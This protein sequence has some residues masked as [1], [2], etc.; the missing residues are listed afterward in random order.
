MCQFWPPEYPKWNYSGNN[1]LWDSGAARRH[2]Q[3]P[4]PILGWHG[5]YILEGLSPGE[6]SVFCKVLQGCVQREGMV[7]LW[8]VCSL[9]ICH[10]KIIVKST[11]LTNPSLM[12]I[13]PVPIFL[14]FT[15][16]SLARM[17]GAIHLIQLIQLVIIRRL[18]C[19]RLTLIY[20]FSQF[21]KFSVNSRQRNTRNW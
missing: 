14:V 2:Q 12:L 7:T 9:C 10:W 13:T 5:T 19:Y 18:P 17:S 1:E 15:G 8:S 11:C 20:L 6:E 21:S 4:L 3:Q 16:V